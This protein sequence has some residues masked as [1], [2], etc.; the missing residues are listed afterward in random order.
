MPGFLTLTREQIV[1]LERRSELP[2][3]DPCTAVY[4]PGELEWTNEVRRDPEQR[5]PLSHRLANHAKLS[6][7]EVAN[8]AVYESRRS[9]RRAAREIVFLDECNVATPA[10]V[11]PPPITRRSNR[12]PSRGL[13]IRMPKLEVAYENSKRDG[14]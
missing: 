14:V 1:K 9:A 10:P 2:A 12:R 3:A 8:A 11:M 4:G 6:V 13:D 7:L 5:L